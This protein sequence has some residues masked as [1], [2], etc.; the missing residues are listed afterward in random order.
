[1]AVPVHALVV[2]AISRDLDAGE[3][4]AQGRPGG[5]VH[6]A[7]AALARLGAQARVVTRVRPEDADTLLATLYA[8]GVQVRALPSRETTTYR[9][10]YSRASDFHELLATSDAIGPGDV[11]QA[12]R[13]ADAIHLGPL[14]R[15]DLDPALPGALSGRIGVD[16]QGLVRSR[17]GETPSPYPHLDELLENVE[18]VQVS[19]SE[20]DA[21]LLGEELEHFARRHEI[22]EMIVTRGA[23]G[24][25]LVTGGRRLEIAA[26]AVEGHFRVGAGDV[27][28]AS[29]LLFRAR[30]LDP[31]AA[32]LGAVE[33]SA[34]KITQGAVP[35]GM[36]PEAVAP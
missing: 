20:L 12:W 2:G 33:V 13:R 30:G 23:R 27:F 16:V 28:L 25:T 19:A 10:D 9:N 14:H 3:P 17:A 21:L 5:V 7:G 32:A 15:G 22:A 1:M 11:P 4:S 31:G 26:R 6:H 29:Y 8:E 24:A 18:V 36:R 35:K 34:A